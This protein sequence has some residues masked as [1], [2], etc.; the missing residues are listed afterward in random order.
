M[1]SKMQSAGHTRD[2]KEKLL[3]IYE[4]EDHK[5]TVEKIYKSHMNGNDN[6]E[7]L[8]SLVMLELWRKKYKVNF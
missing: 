5:K 3:T 6:T 1:L 2:L 4:Q 7:R 8:F